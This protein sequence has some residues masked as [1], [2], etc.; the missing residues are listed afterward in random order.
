MVKYKF[1]VVIAV[2]PERGAEV[3]KSLKK[4]DYPKNKYEVIIEGGRNPS[5]NRNNGAKKSKGEIIFFVDDDAVVETNILKKAEEFFKKYKEIDIVGGPQFTPKDEK[6]FAKI[7]GYVLGSKFGAWKVSNR[8][9]GKKMILEADETMLTS[10]NLFCK[11]GVFKKVHFDPKLY[12]GEDPDFK[13]KKKKQGFGVA[14]YPGIV[15]YHRRRSKFFGL[16][17][18]IYKYGKTRPEKESLIETL[19]MPFFITPSIFLIYLCLIFI[20]FLMN[21]LS[22]LILLP[23]IVYILL[24]LS[25]SLAE[26]LVHMDLIAFFILP[27]IFLAVHLSYGVGFLISS[28]KNIFKKRN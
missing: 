25:F 2:A 11:R 14:Y 23:L 24:N 1:S 26:T 22:F 3:L 10:A 17:Q 20:L 18:Q 21:R 16:I 7:S 5:E 28:I 19:K 8:Y 4:I 12:P 27:F 15:I 6:G 13:K 9:S